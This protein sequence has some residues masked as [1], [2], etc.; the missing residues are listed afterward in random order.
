V[1]SIS[2][3]SC[4][5]SESDTMSSPAVTVIIL[6]WN[7]K[8]LTEE[9]LES[10]RAV[11]YES[12]KVMVVDNAS[13]D[14]S[15]EYLKPKFPEIEFVVNDRNLGFA[16]GNNV[17]IRIALGRGDDYVIL[18]NNDTVV[19]PGLVQ[20]LVEAAE[21]DE[22]IGFAGPKVYF[23]DFKGRKDVI[24]FAGGLI[25]YRKGKVV[26]V[27]EKEAD[28]G[29]YDTEKDY[30]YVEGSS[31]LARADML[32]KIGMLDP[33]YFLYWE[34]IDL[35]V[36]GSAAGYRSIY[37][38]GASIWH[39]I[40]ASSQG[41]GNFYYMMRNRFWFMRRYADRGQYRSFLLYFFGYDLW[42]TARFLVFRRNFGRVMDLFRG[43]IDGLKGRKK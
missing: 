20:R 31:M 7:G 28:A 13:S 24:S 25:D 34:E 21:K 11:S 37:V 17:G 35:C 41:F 42:E 39:K 23:F 2:L 26:H 1:S 8:S 15:V 30:D 36:R 10:M 29:Q 4:C 22:R 5:A 27:G 33:S 43:V 40:G 3:I 9:C 14:G 16:E 32:K 38:P 12:L 6:N 19:D 18:L